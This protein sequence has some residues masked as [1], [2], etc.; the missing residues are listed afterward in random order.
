MSYYRSTT[1]NGKI[2]T[3]SYRPADMFE[4]AQQLSQY[5]SLANKD[6]DGNA[7]L[8]IVMH[9][10]HK[11]YF[12]IYCNIAMAKISEQFIKVNKRLVIPSYYYTSS[13]INGKA[14]A[15]LTVTDNGFAKDSLLSNLDPRIENAI[16]HH[17]LYQWY[18]KIGQPKI[19]ELMLEAILTAELAIN[20]AMAQLLRR[21]YNPGGYQIMWG[22]YL[23]EQD[24]NFTMSIAWSNY[25]CEQGI[26]NYYT[27]PIDPPPTE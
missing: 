25:L 11:D 3:F 20:Q 24:N 2:I 18:T 4:K 26:A 10:D 9:E 16:V 19:A 1:P 21:Y 12:D 23:C 17:V 15:T 5:H 8:D 13:N 27:M 6:K 14:T 7:P 22:N